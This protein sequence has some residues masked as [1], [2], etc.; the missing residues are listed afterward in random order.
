MV[1]ILLIILLVIAIANIVILLTRKPKVDVKSQLKEIESL[2]IKFDASLDRTEK[3]IKDEFQRNR[4]E[5]NEIAKTNREELS[6]SLE[7]FSQQFASNIKELNELLRQKF[8]DFSTQQTE[9]NKQS[10]TNLKELKDTVDNQLKSIRED[11]TKQLDEMRQTVDEKLQKTLNDRLSQSF[12]TV[13]KQL[14]AVQE[15]LG[16]MKTLA[17]DVG[18]LKKVLSNVKMRGGIGEIQLSLLLEQILAPEQYEANV[19]TKTSSSDVVEFAIKLPGRDDSGTKVWLPIDAK[20]PKDIYEQLQEAY[21]VGDTDKI[22]I[23]QKTL[24]STIKKM[25]KDIS[26]KY[27]DPPNTTDFGIM[28]LPFEGIYAEVV[29]KAALLEDLQRNYKIIVTGPTTLAAILNSLQMGF[30]TLAIQKRSGEVW[31]IL[32]AVKKEFVSFGGVLQK[33]QNNI[34]SGLNQLD[35]VVGKRTRAIE[36]KLRSVEA[37]SEAETRNIIPEITDSSLVNDDDDEI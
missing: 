8:S 10:T 3:S 13:G 17:T 15:G 1:E 22:L 24:D 33:A 36:R 31:Q 34:Q 5:T 12:E 21:D 6:K 20:F 4:A 14:Q 11:N 32:G 37:L 29:R 28:F 16:E 26:D 9:L 35:D 2:M 25:A 30:K 7:S 23:A 19:K 18:G 27:I